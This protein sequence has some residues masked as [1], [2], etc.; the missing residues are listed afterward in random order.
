[1][2]IDNFALTMHQACPSKYN[3]RI[4]QGWTARRKSGAL[5]FGAAL[6][7]GLAEW[8][9]SRNLDKALVEISA[10]WEDPADQDDYRTLDRCLDTMAQYAARYSHEN[11]TPVVGPAGPM[12]EVSFSL[13]TGHDVSV[14]KDGRHVIE[15]LEY[16]GI[17]DGLVEM[18][19]NVYVL[20]HKT[21][22]QLGPYYFT[23]Y[24]PNNQVTGYVWAAGQLTGKRVAG[25]I[26]N[27]IGVLKTQTKFERQITT[28]SAEDIA[29]WLTDVRTEAQSIQ[30]H[31]T[32]GHWPMRTPSC[33]MYGKC[34]FH[35]VHVLGSPE[36]Q[37]AMLQAHYV[38]RTWDFEQAAT[39]RKGT[40]E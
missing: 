14:F 5:G 26:I 40:E 30:E 32:G 16:G 22:S 9:R 8:Y 19:S 29:T 38:R 37:D 33:V 7:L 28:R 27:A 18:G 4:N 24:K 21:T 1:M 39:T 35:D 11:F 2:K 15:P 34:E 36:E 17:F 25:A 3:L 20:E 31:A 6:H 10:G 23:Q 13:D 12:L